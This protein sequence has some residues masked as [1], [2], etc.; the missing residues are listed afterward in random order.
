MIHV[1]TRG[2]TGIQAREGNIYIPQDKVMSVLKA[3]GR[4]PGTF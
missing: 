1:C 4:K 3:G 2:M